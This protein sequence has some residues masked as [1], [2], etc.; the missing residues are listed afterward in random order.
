M[1]IA[2]F[3]LAK[4]IDV[5]YRVVINEALELEKKFGVEEGYKYVNGILDRVAKDLRQEEIKSN[6]S[7]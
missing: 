6:V 5:P 1:R 4:R 2:I 3:E 7:K